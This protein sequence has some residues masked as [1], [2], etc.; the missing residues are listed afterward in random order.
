MIICIQSGELN[1]YI[2]TFENRN[3]AFFPEDIDLV[4]ILF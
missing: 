2:D 4:N 1:T 3:T